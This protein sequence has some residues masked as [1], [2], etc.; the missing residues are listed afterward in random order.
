M[1][2]LNLQ[3]IETSDLLIDKIDH[4]LDIGIYELMEQMETAARDKMYEIY[5]QAKE[6]DNET[7]DK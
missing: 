4:V 2:V 7:T 1:P 6:Q 5:E 3:G